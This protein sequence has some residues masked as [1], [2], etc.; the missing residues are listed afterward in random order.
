YAASA[1]A[2]KYSNR[3]LKASNVLAALAGAFSINRYVE[4]STADEDED[5]PANSKAASA[6]LRPLSDVADELTQTS[7][8]RLSSA[9]QSR[10]TRYD[11]MYE[12]KLAMDAGLDRATFETQ[13][14]RSRV[15][16]T[17]ECFRWDWALISDMLEYSIRQPQRLSEALRT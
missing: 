7:H 8:S 11:M 6:D 3:A 14:Q 17:K 12:L 5:D 4:P 13:M 15:L 16:S 2:L 10:T 9:G 1:T